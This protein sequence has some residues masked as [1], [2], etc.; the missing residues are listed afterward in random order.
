M[1]GRDD[2]EGG[3]QRVEAAVVKTKRTETQLIGLAM[4]KNQRAI[5]DD[6]SV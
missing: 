3:I 1:D 6:N 5:I 4:R 2:G